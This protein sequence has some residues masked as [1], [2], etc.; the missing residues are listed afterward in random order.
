MAA[1]TR[2]GAAPVGTDHRSA[3]GAAD[4]KSGFK[5]A[6]T[7]P[8]ACGLAGWRG[9][10]VKLASRRRRDLSSGRVQRARRRPDRREVTRRR[11]GGLRTALRCSFPDRSRRRSAASDTGLSPV[12]IPL[13]TPG[14]GRRTEPSRFSVPGQAWWPEARCIRSPGRRVNR[15]RTAPSVAAQFGPVAAASTDAEAGAEFPRRRQPGPAPSTHRSP[16]RGWA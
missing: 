4:R 15:P 10:G 13:S 12:Q 3:A 8:A 1:R 7:L 9:H 2:S 14:L 16:A 11:F 5:G 6:P